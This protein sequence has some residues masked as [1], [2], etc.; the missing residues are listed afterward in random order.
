[1]FITFDPLEDCPFGDYCK[2]LIV[3]P[4]VTAISQSFGAAS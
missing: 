4:P 3:T 2:N 1:M